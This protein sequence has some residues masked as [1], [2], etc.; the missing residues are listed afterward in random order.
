MSVEEAD[1]VDL[2]VGP[3]NIE[4]LNDLIRRGVKLDYVD[5]DVQDVRNTSIRY[6]TT[7][8]LELVL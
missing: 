8:L 3:A 7:Y 6:R 5:E 1:V 2:S 4:E